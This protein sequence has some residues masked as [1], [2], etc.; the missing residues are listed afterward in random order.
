MT[1]TKELESDLPRR[2]Y[3]KQAVTASSQDAWLLVDLFS[4]RKL[5]QLL[6]ASDNE[7][8]SLAPDLAISMRAVCMMDSTSMVGD[9][10]WLSSGGGFSE[11]AEEEGLSESCDI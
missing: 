9:D 4:E 10:R 8:S 6:A 5:V 3:S 1:R 7:A 2:A 11:L